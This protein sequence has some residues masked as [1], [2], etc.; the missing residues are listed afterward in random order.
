[1]SYGNCMKGVVFAGIVVSA[2]WLVTA[3][4]TGTPQDEASP[5]A[6][7][8]STM[9][10]PAKPHLPSYDVAPGMQRAAA[11]EKR[12]KAPLSAALKEKNLT[13]GD[14]LFIRAFKEEGILEVFLLDQKTQRFQLFRTYPIA[15][16]SGSLGPKQWQGDSQVPEGFYVASN[17][18]LKCDSAFHLAINIGYPNEYDQSLQRTGDYIMIHGNCVSIGCLAMTDEK[19][20]EIYSLI[21]AS[22]AQGQA[23]VRIH[24]FPFRMTE[25]RMKLAE[26]DQW[27]TFWKML[28]VGYDSFEANGLP[29]TTRVEN[30]TYLF[31]PE[32]KP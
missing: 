14:P 5:N 22:L 19:I 17:H 3:Q 32:T 8:I 13:W 31:T 26:Q 25:E 2:I 29:A 11:A 20:E 27:F 7:D 4:I 6:T 21:H 16:Q 18:S 1:M 28:K 10:T 30:Q 15:K 12:V 23:Y 9:T 24:I